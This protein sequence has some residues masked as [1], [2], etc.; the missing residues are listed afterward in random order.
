MTEIPVRAGRLRPLR[1]YRT[2]EEQT[3]QQLREA[4]AQRVLEPGTK[5]VGSQLAVELGVSRIT[6]ANALKRLAGEGFV[7]LSPHKEAIVASLD[8]E[9]L[10]EIFAIRHALEAV[11]LRAAAERV[12]GATVERL[13]A[14]DA[15]L[16]QAADAENVAAFQ[17][18]DREFHLEIYRASHLPLATS[19]LT[20]L[21]DRLE[22]YRK[23]RYDRIGL[24]DSTHHEHA[25]IVAALAAYDAERVIALMEAHVERGHAKYRALLGEQG[26]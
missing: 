15:Q 6:I 3:Y 14:L 12:S 8:E 7:L 10:R 9:N 5:L 24:A 25:E 2:L 20:D 11:T 22:P 21:W 17:R 16:Q 13:R 19:L 26:A 18:L 1:G 4:I 23:Q